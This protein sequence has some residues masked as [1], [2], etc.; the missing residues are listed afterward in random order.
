MHS[1]GPDIHLGP[2]LLPGEQLWGGVGRTSTLGA[3]RVR[4]SQDP[5]A[6]AQAKI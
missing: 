4:I 5:G 3:E 6:V 2:V 1:H